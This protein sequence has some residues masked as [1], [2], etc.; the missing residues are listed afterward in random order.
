MGTHGAKFGVSEKPSILDKRIVG[1]FKKRGKLMGRI[2]YNNGLPYKRAK[3]GN[4]TNL[5][6]AAIIKLLCGRG[7]FVWRANNISF[8][9]EGVY[10]KFRGLRGIPD[11]VGFTRAGRFLGIEVKTGRDVQSLWQQNFQEQSIRRGALYFVAHDID[12]IIHEK[13]LL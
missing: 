1:K 3:R 7:H 10:I 13:E 2:I 12:E 9:K 4:R 8:C 5:L 11:V 6:T